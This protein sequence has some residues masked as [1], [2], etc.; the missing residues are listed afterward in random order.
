MKQLMLT[1]MYAK[2]RRA[3]YHN[4]CRKHWLFK[5]LNVFNISGGVRVWN[6]RRVL[7]RWLGKNMQICSHNLSVLILLPQ[8]WQLINSADAGS[9]LT[10][11]HF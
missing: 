4:V 5:V 7:R 8:L 1:F 9:H 2:Y 10:A 6:G 3:K 11:L